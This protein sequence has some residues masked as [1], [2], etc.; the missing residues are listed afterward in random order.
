[1]STSSPSNEKSDTAV[2]HTHQ[3]HIDARTRAI[4]NANAKLANPLRGIPHD[5]L[6]MD[7][8][9]FAH[10]RGL[11]HILPELKK[12]ALVAQDPTCHS[13]LD[14]FSDEDR[15]ILTQ[16][17]T[18]KWRQTFTLY[19]MVVMSS[20]AAA[21]QGMD[22]AVINGAQIIYPKQFGIG[23]PN[24]K[25]DSWLIGLI[26]SAPYLCCATISCWLTHPLNDYL[27]RKN[28]I[29]LTC[30]ISFLTCIWS[31]LTNTWWH[32]FISRFFRHCSWRPHQLHSTSF[33]TPMILLV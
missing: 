20:L 1:M 26:N 3:S 11:T 5:R 10:E 22:E 31:G 30:M 17:V 4:A 9:M 12:G 15:R 7:V 27:G 14:V 6:M 2:K 21:V 24:S 33:L 29:F 23:D 18:H 32:L 25:R 28:T 13:R 16:E 19:Y 8:E